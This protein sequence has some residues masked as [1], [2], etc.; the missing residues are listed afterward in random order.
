MVTYPE[1]FF[2]DSL[3]TF[4]TNYFPC[5]FSFRKPLNIFQVCFI[6]L[7][8][9]LI[10]MLAS[11]TPDTWVLKKFDSLWLQMSLICLSWLPY[12]AEPVRNST[13]FPTESS[14]LM[15]KGR[16]LLACPYCDWFALILTGLSFLWVFLSLPR[17][18]LY[19]ISNYRRIFWR[20]YTV[21]HHFLLN[22]FIYVNVSTLSFCWVPPITT[23]GEPV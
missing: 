5:F 11:P 21:W 14:T 3:L 8:E 2:T 19:T 16:K 1:S 15:G 10:N 20:R 6:V 18:F 12:T 13:V 9:G 23:P 7:G 4:F 22:C 17:K